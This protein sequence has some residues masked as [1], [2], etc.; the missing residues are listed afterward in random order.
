MAANT[1]EDV[2]RL[3]GERVN[4]QSPSITSTF[5]ASETASSSPLYLTKMSMKPAWYLSYSVR[6]VMRMLATM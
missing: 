4:G 1:P 5:G 6:S 2:D 3:F